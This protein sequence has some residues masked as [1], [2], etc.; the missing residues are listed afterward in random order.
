MVGALFQQ[1]EEHRGE[2]RDK[3]AKATH[4]VDPQ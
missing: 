3:S 1:E 2:Q 4:R